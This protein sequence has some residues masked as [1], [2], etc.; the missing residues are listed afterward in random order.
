MWLSFLIVAAGVFMST[1]DGSMVNIALPAIMDELQAPLRS[2]E[3]VV[4]IYLLTIT[5]TL[6]FWGYL[7]DR[8][9]RRRIYAV[10]MLVFALGSLA[11]FL[12]P[13]LRWLVLARLGQALGAAMMMATG[14]AMVKEIFPPGQ[15]GRG[16][17]LIGIAVS[18]GLMA[19]PA[20]GGFLLDA[21]SWRAIFLV[22]VP[23]GLALFAPALRLLP[24]DRAAGWRRFDAAGAMLWL[25][26]LT[27]IVVALSRAS[28]PK[29]AGA[30]DLLL[31]AGGILILG[32]LVKVELLVSHPFLPLHLFREGFFS[33]GMASAVLSF[34][35]LFTVLLLIPF[36]LDRIL[37]L[38]GT[39]LGLVMMATPATVLVVAPIAGRLADRIGSRLLTTA[40]MLLSSTGLLL[41]ANLT[42]GQ[43]P[44][45]VAWRMALMGFGQALFLSPNSASVLGGVDKHYVGTASAL[46]ATARNLGMLLGIAQAGLLFSLFFGA[47]SGGLDLHLF[48][49]AHTGAFMLGLNHS[50]LITAGIGLAGAAISWRRES[51]GLEPPSGRS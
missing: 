35:L 14:P 17:G 31:L 34:V 4:M 7:A 50:L 19:G 2:T 21:F 43:Q 12:A 44:W 15:L 22:T 30:S 47:Y 48:S 9:G 13:Q 42:P 32:L 41:L 33:I 8:I 16:L 40:G 24:P 45:E 49:P 39:H 6:L 25:L 3:W 26:A 38:S 5:A 36:Y 29:G 11:C 28:A 20:I 27:A 23:V 10:G 18:L 1:M 51:E 37:G 46:L